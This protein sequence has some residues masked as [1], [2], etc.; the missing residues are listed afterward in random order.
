MG[1][2]RLACPFP[3]AGRDLRQREV[4]RGLAVVRGQRQH[5]PKRIARRGEAA[6]L[7]IGLAEH[8]AII[9]DL[10]TQRNRGL[11]ERDG[12]VIFAAGEQGLR[13]AR[14]GQSLLL[15]LALV[16]RAGK[17]AGAMLARGTNQG[18][19]E[20]QCRQAQCEHSPGLHDVFPQQ[21]NV[22]PW[23]AGAG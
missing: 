18:A 17:G 16:A 15:V 9:A 8:H 23:A 12:G 22:V 21:V 10:R 20:R 3:V 11:G 1:G 7:E 19:A 4:E 5:V 2:K 14:I 6:G 13:L